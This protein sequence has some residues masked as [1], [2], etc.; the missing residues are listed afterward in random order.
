MT[1]KRVDHEVGD[2]LVLVEKEGHVIKPEDLPVER[3]PQLAYPMDPR[4]KI[5][6]DESYFNQAALVRPDPTQFS[7]EIRS[8][9]VDGVVAY[10]VVCT[11]HGYPVSMW[12][13]DTKNPFCSCHGSQLDPRDRAKVTDGPATRRLPMLPLKLVDGRPGGGGRVHGSSAPHEPLR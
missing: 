8:R 3:P 9:A 13:A 7:E 4:D 5:V 2:Q 11:R 10:S 6:R 1:R 12:K